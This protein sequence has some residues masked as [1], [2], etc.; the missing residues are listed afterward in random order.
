[1]TKMY[2]A[3]SKRAIQSLKNFLYCFIDGNGEKIV[4]KLQ[5]FNLTMNYREN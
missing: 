2:T 3:I 5:Q 1:M 4:T